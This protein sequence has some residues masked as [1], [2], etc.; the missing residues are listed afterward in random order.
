MPRPSSPR[1]KPCDAHGW[2]PRPLRLELSPPPRATEHL[3]EGRFACSVSRRRRR[4][5]RL[6][7]LRV[8]AVGAGA[9]VAAFLAINFSTSSRPFLAEAKSG[10]SLS[11]AS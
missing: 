4:A 3:G 5:P 2:R 8:G 10:F 1:R 6:S 9:A 7:G 11:A